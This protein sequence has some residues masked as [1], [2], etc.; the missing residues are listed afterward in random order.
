MKKPV[1][2]I[3]MFI[4]FLSLSCLAFGQYTGSF[5]DVAGSKRAGASDSI[6]GF[7]PSKAVD[8]SNSTYAAVPGTAPAW[9][10]VDLGDYYMIDGFG[11]NLT[12]NAELPRS[13]IFRV[14]QDSATWTDLS[15]ESVG[16]SGSYSYDVVSPDP[17]RY[18]QIYM[19]DKDALA[20]FAEISVFG[21]MLMA[22]DPPVPA[23]ASNVTSTSFTANWNPSLRADGYVLSVATDP[24]FTNHVDG[25]DN[26]WVNVRL[27]W[28]V[29]NLEP[30]TSYYFRVRAYN[31]AG[32]S[33]F[34][35]SNSVLTAKGEQVITFE[36]MAIASYG[37]MDF[38]P[39]VSS[40]SGL[41]ITLSSS[42]ESVAR[43]VGTTVSIVGVGTAAIT[44]EQEGDSQYNP[45]S[46]VSRDLVV[47]TKDISVS[48]AVAENKIYD[49]T[50]A[51]V[52]TGAN[53]VGVVGSDDVSLSG[54]D[55]G[56]FAQV[57]AGND[58]AVTATM[59]ISGADVDK[60]SFVDTT[61]LTAS[62]TQKEL[63]VLAD[64][65]SREECDVNP[66]FTL[67][68]SGFV[69][70]EDESVLDTQPEVSCSADENSEDGTYDIIVS[71]GSAVNYAF[72]YTNGTLTVTPDI[73]DPVLVVKDI[74]VQ[75]D[76]NNSATIT[77]ADV[78]SSVDDN[79][80]I[81]DTLLSQSDFSEADI[82][83]FL[84]D[85]T[86]SDASGNQS[87]EQA[88]VTVVGS[89]GLG[90]F[91]DVHARIYPSPTQGLVHVELNRMADELKVMDITGKTI[92]RK[93][94]VG[95]EDSLD[96]SEYQSGIYLIQLKIGKEV[97]FFK[98]LKK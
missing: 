22:P 79:C 7:E 90:L 45:A 66:E 36:E 57:N 89:T 3:K 64:D 41:P 85:V 88:V 10:G 2:F 60:Y 19:T 53:L 86:V 65:Q 78:V 21:E 43:V 15:T 31:L 33:S 83:D 51:A 56:V 52:I 87:T 76:E 92:I 25:Y 63:N 59:S 91:E 58:I 24:L 18:V 30:G 13:Y 70:S 1:L 12:R 47:E 74:T 6:A 67:T 54:S 68:Y 42:D 16:G 34:G 32:T 80:S 17:V 97:R 8:G 73:T 20:S 71:G 29:Q 26:L 94:N 62:I 82:G 77:P 9:I 44:A 98:I 28:D 11:L 5:P 46:P 38:D 35:N 50:D 37:D 48:G 39:V 23:E 14:S 55:A 49:G 93:T 40:S 84:V 96:L 27:F 75:L 72:I 81:A 95:N 61:K 69:G 4:I